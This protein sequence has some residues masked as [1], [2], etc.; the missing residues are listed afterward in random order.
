VNKS[1]LDKTLKY[2]QFRLKKRETEP[3]QYF[4]ANNIAYSL[5]VLAL[6]GR[7]DPVAMSYYRANRPLLTEDSKFLLACTQSILGNQRAYREL[8][9]QQF[10]PQRPTHRALDGSFY[11]PIRDEGLVLN[12]LVSTDPNN[13]QIPGIARQLSRQ[14]KAAGWLSTQERAFALLALGK[15][16]RQNARSTATSSLF[17]DGKPAGNFDGKDLTL[18][19]VANHSVSIRTA[20]SGSLYYYWETEGISASGQVKEEDSFL[21]VRRQFLNR[22]GVPLGKPVFNQNDLVVVKITLEAAE[23]AGQVKNV[24]ITDLLP[25]S[26]EIENPR[27][28]PLRELS[29]A[30]D[31]ATPDYLDVRDDRINLFTTAILVAKL[32]ERKKGSHYLVELILPDSE[33]VLLPQAQRAGRGQAGYVPVTVLLMLDQGHAAARVAQALDTVMKS[34]KSGKIFTFGPLKGGPSGSSCVASARLRGRGYFFFG[35]VGRVV[36]RVVGPVVFPEG[37]TEQ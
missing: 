18:R 31:A 2:L 6:A 7:Q 16:A 33:R 36:V 21:K 29:W 8:L 28:G 12:A 1:V 26:L 23:S 20:G 19:N 24:A 13:P 32:K 5:Y 3:Y 27:I 9:P 22:D 15:I 17:I 30:K 25:A 34:K 14:M 4:D 35:H 10:G 37:K 11:S